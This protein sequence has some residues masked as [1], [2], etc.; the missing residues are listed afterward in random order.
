MMHKKTH[1][2][3]STVPHVVNVEDS[4]CVLVASESSVVRGH[5]EGHKSNHPIVDHCRNGR[6]QGEANPYPH[7]EDAVM[8]TTKQAIHYVMNAHTI[9]WSVGANRMARGPIFCNYTV[10]ERGTGPWQE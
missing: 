10:G 3:I 9:S 1:W 8:W 2:E 4:A 6:G 7:F 5:D